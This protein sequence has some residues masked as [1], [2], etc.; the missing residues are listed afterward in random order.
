MLCS[1]ETKEKLGYRYVPPVFATYFTDEE[2]PK[3]RL[4]QDSIDPEVAYQI[5]KDDLLDEGGR[6]VYSCLTRTVFA[7]R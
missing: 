6:L 1:K 5:V 7:R 4:G 2:M 3:Y